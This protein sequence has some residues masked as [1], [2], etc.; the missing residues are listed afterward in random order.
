MKLD[1][2]A[3]AARLRA[4]PR[5]HVALD[6]FRDSAVLVPIVVEPG[7]PDRLLFT[8]RRADL[9]NH[10]GQISFPGGKR[11]P[12][13]LDAQATAIREAA[14][15]LAIEPAAVEVLG[16]LDDVPT[17]SRFVITPVV[18]RLRGPLELTPS[19][20]EVA[21]VFA[22]P[23]DELGAPGCYTDGGVRSF[24]GITYAMHEYRWQSHVIWGA[25]ARMVHQLLAMMAPPQE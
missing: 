8:V 3:L 22:A 13:D 19:A 24:L 12:G 16:L 6:G 4:R 14:E 11:D 20:E 23:L 15:E 5:L 18:A 17:P 10:A 25:T 7:A 1:A 9:T 21:Q 2:Q